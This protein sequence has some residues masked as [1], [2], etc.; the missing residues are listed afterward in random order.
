MIR[1]PK[2]MF[3][4]IAAYAVG[5][6]AVTLLH[7]GVYWLLAEPVRVDAYLA[8]TIAAIVA[9]ITGYLLHSRWTFGHTNTAA[10]G[11]GAPGRFVIVSL[12]AYFLNSFWVW[13]F[14]QKLSLGVTL[15]IVPMI[16]VTP[17]FGFALNRF[18]TFRS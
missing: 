16:L 15:S 6:G 9:G 7:S 18:W 5:G 2:T 3:G 13:L 4:Q 11:L 8:N 14:V 17:W 1:A 10:K 12:L